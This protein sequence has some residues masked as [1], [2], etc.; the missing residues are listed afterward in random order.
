MYVDRDMKTEE[1]ADKVQEYTQPMISK[2]GER[3]HDI[4]S[5]VGE[6]ARN[7]GYSADDYVHHHPWQ[8]VAVVGLVACLLGF[9]FGNRRD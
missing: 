4:Q 5:R 2:V 6:S 7:I 9:L 1:Y 8:T 3:F